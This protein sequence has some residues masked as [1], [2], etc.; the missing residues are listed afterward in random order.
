MRQ[1]RTGPSGSAG[2][3]VAMWAY[4]GMAVAA[5]VVLK[6]LASLVFATE[7]VGAERNERRANRSLRE[8]LERYTAR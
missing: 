8:R 3:L 2:I 1:K 7:R 6:L 4:V 5:L